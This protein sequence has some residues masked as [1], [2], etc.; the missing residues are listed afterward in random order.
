MSIHHTIAVIG[1]SADRS[2]FGNK[3]VRAFVRAG[4]QVFPVHPSANAIEGLPVFR[5][6]AEVP[7]VHLD[8]VSVYLPPAVMMDVLDDMAMRPIG[9]LWLNPGADA[10]QVAAKARQL[11]FNVIC[12]CSIVAIGASPHE[13]T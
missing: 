11:G 1:A 2:K 8:R 9:E 6:L 3:C 12:A 5:S 13:L 7:P 10:P 4:W